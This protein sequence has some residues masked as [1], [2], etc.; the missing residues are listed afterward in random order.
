MKKLSFEKFFILKL[1]Q[2]HNIIRGKI[3]LQKF[4]YFLTELCKDFSLKFEK[5][6]STKNY[7]KIINL[8]LYDH[9]FIKNRIQKAR[10]YKK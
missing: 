1:V 6:K 7:G 5:W 8:I 4:F 3:V 9:P 10:N 2:S